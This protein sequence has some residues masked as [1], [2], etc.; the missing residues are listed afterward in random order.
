MKI[1][2]SIWQ[3]LDGKKTIIATIYWSLTQG[4]SGP[5]A[6]PNANTTIGI[7]SG[8]AGYGFL[9]NIEEIRVDTALETY[10]YIPT[11]WQ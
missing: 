8:G 1:L 4:Y 6:Y 9:G 10:T 11:T 2:K 5:I 3:W 7:N